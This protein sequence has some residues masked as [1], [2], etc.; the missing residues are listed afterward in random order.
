MKTILISGC[1]GFIGQNLIASLIDCYRIIGI[2][3]FYSS[4]KNKIKPF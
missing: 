4:N 1:A 2:D 3:N